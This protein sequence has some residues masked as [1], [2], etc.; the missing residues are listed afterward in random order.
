MSAEMALLVFLFDI[1]SPNAFVDNYMQDYVISC[2][3]AMEHVV[4]RDRHAAVM[5]HS[6][7]FRLLPAARDHTPPLA[8]YFKTKFPT[9]EESGPFWGFENTK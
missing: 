8:Q 4:V 2:R 6:A 7:Y 3:T 9:G 5:L 1:L